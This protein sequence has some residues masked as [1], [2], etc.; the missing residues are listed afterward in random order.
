MSLSVQLVGS[1]SVA[2]ASGNRIVVVHLPVVES[3]ILGGMM[4]RAEVLR[5]S[6]LC[7]GLSAELCL[8]GRG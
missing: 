5:S 4:L 7:W 6:S 8:E 2:F 1:P 3:R